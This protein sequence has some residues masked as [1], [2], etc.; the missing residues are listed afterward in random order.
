MLRQLKLTAL[1]TAAFI[2]T[3]CS[4]MK[5]S[6]QMVAEDSPHKKSWS[7]CAFEGGMTLGVPAALHSLGAGGAAAVAGAMVAGIHC[8]IADQTPTAIHFGFGS[9]HL[10]VNDRMILDAVAARLGKNKRVELIGHTCNIGPDQVNQVLSENR[11]SAVKNY[12]MTRGISAS[13]IQTKGIGYR[14]P[15]FSNK[16]EKTRMKNRRVEMIIHR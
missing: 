13:R 6:S 2:L 8:A 16:K 1:F 11:A 7:Q 9:T 10:D 4:V 5:T 12:L 3:G 15:A 14:K